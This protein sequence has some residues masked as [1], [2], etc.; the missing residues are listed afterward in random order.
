LAPQEIILP[1]YLAIVGH[2]AVG[3]PIGGREPAAPQGK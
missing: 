2:E 3:Q 1:L